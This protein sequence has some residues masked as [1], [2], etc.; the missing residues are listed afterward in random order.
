M[1]LGVLR[2]TAG[3]LVAGAGSVL[4]LLSALTPVR[5]AGARPAQWI[6]VGLARA[7][8]AIFAVRLDAPPAPVIRGH[9]GLVFFNH[10]TYLDAI[11]LF[12][13]GP[14]RFLATEGVR[15]IPF[16]GWI[17]RAVDSFFVDRSDRASRAASRDRIRA[18][19][20]THPTPPVTLAPEGQ[21]GPGGGVLPFRRGAFEI[22]VETGLPIMPLLL[23]YEP[24]DAVV[25]QQKELLLVALWRLGARTGGAVARVV[26]LPLIHPGSASTEDE[27]DAEAARLAEFAEQAFRERLSPASLDGAPHPIPNPQYPIPNLTPPRSAG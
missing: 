6:T 12:A 2:V 25:W 22:A 19:L 10:L 11:V 16:I 24:F 15:G 8:L 14:V 5:I 9:R 13:R 3:V 18:A 20:T 1:V 7:F 23:E 27:E 26:P 17:A 21:I 4:V